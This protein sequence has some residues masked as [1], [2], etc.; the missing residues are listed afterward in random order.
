[1]AAPM[2]DEI[3]NLDMSQSL[4]QPNPTTPSILGTTGGSKRLNPSPESSQGTQKLRPIK[5]RNSV[6]DLRDLANTSKKTPAS[7]KSLT[8]KILEA[9]KSPEILD[10]IIPVLA[11]KLSESLFAEMED[12][13]NKQVTEQLQ[14]MK[15]QLESQ[16]QVIET[17]KVKITK[18]F[19]DLSSL[20]RANEGQIQRANQHQKDIQ[21]LIGRIEELESRLENQEQYSRRTSLRFHNISVPVDERGRIKHPVDTDQLVLGIIHDKLKLKDI[22]INDIGRSHVIGKVGRNGKTQVIVRF[23]S[24]RTRNL[25]FTNKK[26]LK[27]DTDGHYITENLTKYRSSLVLRLSKLKYEKSVDS[28]WTF[29]GRIYAKKTTSSPKMLIRNP[30]DIDDLLNSVEPPI[31]TQR[32]PSVN[33]EDHSD[34][35]G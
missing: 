1:M 12:E 8:D 14:P 9:L 22:T 25:V 3:K 31:E 5:R 7:R 15:E 33:I 30:Y 13:V 35:I 18:Q 29:D 20:Q 10:V 19:I 27:N 17:Q 26:Q 4:S 32:S 24:Y 23:L 28:Y 6:G 16:A 11:D 2:D 21:Y 34:L